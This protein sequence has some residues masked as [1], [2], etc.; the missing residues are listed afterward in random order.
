MSTTT[1]LLSV[2]ENQ[3]QIVSSTPRDTLTRDNPLVVR[4]LDASPSERADIKCWIYK[5]YNGCKVLRLELTTSTYNQMPVH[6]LNNWVAQRTGEMPFATV[7]LI[8]SGHRDVKIAVTHS[9]VAEDVTENSLA[10]VID[11][12]VYMW[13]KSV[14][15]LENTEQLGEE[16]DE[17]ID[18]ATVLSQLGVESIDELLEK[19]DE[20]EEFAVEVEQ[21]EPADL[22]PTQ[23]LAQLNQM[24]GLEP[25]KALVQQLAAQQQVAQQ[26]E[27]LGLKAVIPS[28]HLVFLGNPGTG[29][30]TVARLIGQLYKAL[31]LLKSGHVIEAERSSLIAAYLGQTALKTRAVCEQALN[32]V[33]FI[34]EAYSLAVD[35]R[36]YGQ[37]AIETLLTFMES[38]RN[39]FVL[40]VAG[41]PEKMQSFMA[42]NPGLRSRFDVAI[43]FPDYTTDEL[44]QMFVELVD[45]NDYIADSKVIDAVR[46]VIDSWVRD[47]G[48][49]NGRQ[50]RQLFNN[51]VGNHATKMALQTKCSLSD[52]KTLTVDVVP[53][54][55]VE[56]DAPA[57]A[58]FN[59]MGY[60]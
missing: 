40:V 7:R 56:A 25:V 6:E 9:M 16:C 18:D 39:E 51:V 37:E 44:T 28:P 4:P 31:G 36:D 2:F 53:P 8:E 52:L 17:E 57:A 14:K 49:G 35:G 38:H 59:A 58:G 29:K 11:G 21:I 54:V 34:D 1:K 23:I 47:E 45:S 41:Y 48:F 26:R 12:M 33:L 24:I 13:R 32:G 43:P 55:G 46:T 30:T 10:Q 5:R 42:S 3:T 22:S 19:F 15:H 60:L 27:R 20:D 50:V